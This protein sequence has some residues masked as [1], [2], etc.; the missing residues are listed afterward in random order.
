M[1]PELGK[2]EKEVQA[3]SEHHQNLQP[4]PQNLLLDVTAEA[5]AC[6]CVSM[7]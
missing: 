5:Q 1:R 7:L 3:P 2:S 4:L 6:M